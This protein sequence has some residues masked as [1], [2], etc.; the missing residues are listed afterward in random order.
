MTK[1]SD[2]L[3]A[4]EN[5]DWEVYVA[6]SEDLTS[7]NM[8]SIDEELAKQ[9]TIFSYYSGLYEYA[10]KDHDILQIELDEERADA[11]IRAQQEGEQRSGKRPTA[12]ILDA[13]VTSDPACKILVRNLAD[14]SS[15]VGLLKRLMNALSQKKD[16][17]VQIASAQREEKKIYS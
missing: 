8:N 14:C 7:I 2:L 1:A 9:A 12:N 10:K 15:K 16:T 11:R 13:Y 17:L 6:L 5:L 4:Y 3:L